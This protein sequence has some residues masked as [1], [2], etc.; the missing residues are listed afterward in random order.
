MGSYQA[1]KVKRVLYEKKD[2][3]EIVSVKREV[4]VKPGIKF[5]E[6]GRWKLA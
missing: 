5:D 2:F 6:N 3:V 1:R 4:V